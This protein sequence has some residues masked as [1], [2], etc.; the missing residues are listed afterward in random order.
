MSLTGLVRFSVAVED[1]AA[2]V[3]RFVTVA[4]GEVCYKGGRWTAA[5]NAVG[6]RVGDTVIELISPTGPGPVRDYLDRYGER[7][8]ST[9]FGVTSLD[10]AERY[11]RDKGISMTDGD[12]PGA[13]AVPAAQNHGLLF[14]FTEEPAVFPSGSSHTY[15]VVHTGRPS[16]SR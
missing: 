4:G 5:A 10:R 6:L 2:A 1:L 13:R 15:S 11:L 3:N 12:A 8:R 14:E 7:I 16:A 9:V